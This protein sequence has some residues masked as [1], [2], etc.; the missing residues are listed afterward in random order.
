M[1]ESK[2]KRR[3]TRVV[4]CTS[5]HEREDARILLKQCVSLASA[6]YDVSLIVADGKGDSVFSGV[7][8]L[9]A[10]IRAPRLKRMLNT[11][12]KVYRTAMALDGDIYHLHDPEL[13]PWGLMIKRAGKRVI[14]DAHEDLSEQIRSKAYLPSVFRYSI[15]K[16][17]GIVQHWICAR[18]DFVV[19]ATPVIAEKF[20]ARGIASQAI[21]NYPLLGELESAASSPQKRQDVCYIGGISAVRGIRQIID[22]MALAKSGARLNLAGRFL[23]KNLEPELRQTAG[24]KYVDALGFLNRQGVRKVLHGSMAG[25]VTLLP[26][27]AFKD[28]LPVK[29]FEYMSAGLPVIASDF[30]L[31]R[32]IIAGNDCGLLVD[33]ENPQDI[34]DAIDALV[35]DPEM[36]RRMGENGSRAVKEK[37]NWGV[38]EKKL[39]ALYSELIGLPHGE[40]RA[41]AA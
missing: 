12:G 25:L 40:A 1:D 7:R 26:T 27:Q 37:Y 9:D 31:W 16:L 18:L 32:Q 14:F 6:G 21:C 20:Q 30:P 13:M 24:W 22:A 11:T 41:G 33:P 19:A 2:D 17:S 39:L 38:E 8:I 15:G 34:A 28:S 10:G 23:E 5:V 29:M 4:H 36:A 35:R 3:Q